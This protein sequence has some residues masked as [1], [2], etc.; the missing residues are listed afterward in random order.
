MQNWKMKK[1]KV[2]VVPYKESIQ[3]L[4]YNIIISGIYFTI[5]QFRPKEAH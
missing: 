4:I 1:N 5:L 2:E 3:N